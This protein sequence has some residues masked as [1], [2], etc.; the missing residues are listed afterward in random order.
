[1]AKPGAGLPRRD[2]LRLGVVGG[3]GLAG[4]GAAGGLAALTWPRGQGTFGGV[5]DAGL[6]DDIRP[7]DVKSYRE[8]KFYLARYAEPAL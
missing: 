2:L 1:M 4:L 8:G 5:I 7:G 3:L 6:V